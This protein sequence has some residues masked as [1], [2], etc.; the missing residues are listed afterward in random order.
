MYS[1]AHIKHIQTS[2]DRYD[3]QHSELQQQPGTALRSREAIGDFQGQIL[4]LS[5]DI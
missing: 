1:E 3:H 5:F 4:T 2:L